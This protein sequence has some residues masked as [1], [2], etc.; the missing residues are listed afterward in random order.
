MHGK[1]SEV[2]L[3]TVSAQRLAVV[4]IERQQERVPQRPGLREIR[5]CSRR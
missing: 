5:L 4:I 3:A 2:C 1:C